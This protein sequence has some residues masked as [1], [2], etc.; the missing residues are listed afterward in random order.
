[1]DYKRVSVYIKRAILAD[2]GAKNIRI[3]FIDNLSVKRT[4][5]VEINFN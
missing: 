3:I 5:A 2:L 1:M 4:E